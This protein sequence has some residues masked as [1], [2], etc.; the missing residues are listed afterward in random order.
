MVRKYCPEG[1][2]GSPELRYS[3]LEFL[4]P[5][6][7]ECCNCRM[8][9]HRCWRHAPEA[10][11]VWPRYFY[12]ITPESTSSTTTGALLCIWRLSTAICRLFTFFY[13][14]R[15]LLTGACREAVFRGELLFTK[16]LQL[17]CEHYTATLRRQEIYS[18]LSTEIC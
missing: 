13:N 6:F 1:A 4:L 8:A 14:T 10:I 9:G 18:T 15:R 11:Q 3:F 2:E 16:V 12:S 5:N 7:L 17:S